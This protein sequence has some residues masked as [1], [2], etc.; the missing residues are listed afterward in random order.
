LATFLFPGFANGSAPAWNPGSLAPG[1]GNSAFPSSPSNAAGVGTFGPRDMVAGLS[2]TCHPNLTPAQNI[3]LHTRQAHYMAFQQAMLAHRPMG[4]QQST[5]V[6]RQGHRQG[7]LDR[8]TLAQGVEGG[9]ITRSEFRALSRFQRETEFLRARLREGGYSPAEVAYLEQRSQ[10]YRQMQQAF[11]SEDW[12]FPMDRPSNP[13]DQ[14]L[15]QLYDQARSGESRPDQTEHTLAWFDYNA[16]GAGME[17]RQGPVLDDERL[18]ARVRGQE[19]R[20]QAGQADRPPGPGA[21]LPEG[22]RNRANNVLNGLNAHFQQLDSNGNGS[23][24]HAEMRAILANP[25]QFGYTSEE[26]AALFQRHG[27]I[28]GIDAN[29]AP[30]LRNGRGQA[31]ITRQDLRAPSPTEG[32]EQSQRRSATVDQLA[33][34][35]AQHA[36]E[37]SRP[38]PSR[39][40]FGP[41]GRPDPFSIR[42]NREGSCWLL[43][44]MSQMRPEEI[45]NMVRQTRDG[46]VMV[47][48]PGR[49]PEVVSSLTEAERRIYSN[50]NGDWAAYIEK[51][52]AQHYA[53]Q[54]QNINGGRGPRAFELLRGSSGQIISMRQPGQSMDGRDP[55]QVGQLIQRALSEG[56]MVQTGISPD[57]FNP[58][59]SNASSG[60]HAYAVVGFDP[61]TQTVTLRN[62]WGKGERA[63]RDHRD[64][65]LFTMSLREFQVTFSDLDVENPRFQ[66]PSFPFGGLT[67]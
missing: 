65:G 48:F 18:R 63:D 7:E 6:A 17:G 22:D 30:H 26:A 39:G 66:L 1:S 31:E 51:A 35:I 43:A 64:D 4:E 54:D 50:S 15:D 45:Q 62:P 25:R 52:A 41:E 3:F 20:D 56:R 13:V 61:R 38:A 60:G 57:D 9:Q 46:Q 49:A 19:L 29:D 53:R 2:F 11:L 5:E 67:R 47:Q 42:Q 8:R 21:P 10:Q 59:V 24:S 12:H 34:G 16:Y 58:Q 36:S 28:A 14:K 55:A 27:Q 32:K 23:I 44:A 40:L 37:S 33:A